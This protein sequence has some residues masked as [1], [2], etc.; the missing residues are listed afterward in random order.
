MEPQQKITTEQTAEQETLEPGQLV[1]KAKN[2]AVRERK[3]VEF[4]ASTTARKCLGCGDEFRS[5]GSHNRLC[6]RCRSRR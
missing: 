4:E 5:E 1:R 3:R 2:A 6:N